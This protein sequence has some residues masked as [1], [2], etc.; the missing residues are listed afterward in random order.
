MK[1][2]IRTAFILLSLISYPC[3]A[4]GPPAA[5]IASA[6]PLA[7]QAGMQ[8]IKQGGNAFDAAVAI[9]ATLAVV[10]PY[11]SG[12]GGGG[13]WLIHRA[14]DGKQVML[15]G[16]E[17]AP[18]LAHARMYQD[19]DGNII[20][21][22]SL[23]GPLAAGIPGIPAGIVHLA[24]KYGRLPLKQ[25]L[26]A[27][28][29]HAK[30]GFKVTKR[31]QNL[32]S[33]RLDKLRQYPASADIFLD[34]NNIPQIGH[35]IVQKDLARTLQLIASK[36]ADGFYR[37]ELAEKMVQ[38]VRQHGGIWSL[39]DLQDYKLIERKPVIA[40]YHGIKLISAPP[41]SS[42]GIVMAQV[43]GIL[44]NFDLSAMDNIARKH[45]VIEAM[46]RAYRDRAVYLG[47][48][49]YFDV[50]V[51]RLL[52]HDYLDGLALNIDANHATPSAELSDTP[53]LAQTGTQTTHFSVIDT[54]G[55][56]VAA[57]LSINIIFGSNFVAEGTG[58]LLNDEMDDFSIKRHTAN[59]YGLIGDKANAIE[60]GKRPLSS[61]S[62]TFLETKDR[63]AILGT[64]GGSRIISMVLLAAL[65]FAEGNL[66][67][68][69]VSLPRYHHQYLPDVVQF[70]QNGLSFREQRSL[71]ALGHKL[72]EKN[73]RYGN[74]Q[75][76]LWD[77]QANKVYA[78]S[79]PRGEGEAKVIE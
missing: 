32:A 78:A 76:I 43:F 68:S 53:G 1:N 79:D 56:R 16:R 20:R 31:Y 8:I 54:E 74:M 67:D 37:G 72:S 28:I 22:L 58:V 61:M 24:E 47:D 6:H 39:K 7:T 2:L 27:A 60:A 59:A 5:A 30:K 66:P 42:G 12:L 11:A 18:A 14:S 73:R 62:P 49:D 52:N 75:A 71:R 64:P 46:R 19:K 77:K 34:N 17:T 4:A 41:P 35:R 25:T 48:P 63:V 51:A 29:R 9:T 57:T 23:N 38:S 50:P 44:A 45:H 10:E 33:Y 15:D 69:W 26:K 13:F 70:E 55:N 65:D 3:L 36:G 21:G 40:H